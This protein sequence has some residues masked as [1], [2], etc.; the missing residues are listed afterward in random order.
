MNDGEASYSLTDWQAFLQAGCGIAGAGMSFILPKGTNCGFLLLEN[1][2]NR[3]ARSAKRAKKS[4]KL[5]ALGVTSTGSVQGFAVRKKAQK[6]T[7][8]GIDQNKRQSI[9]K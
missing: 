4:L 7:E 2:R 9:A 5:R 8:F 1:H 6:V 3:T